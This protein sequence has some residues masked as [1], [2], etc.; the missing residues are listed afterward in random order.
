MTPQGRVCFDLTRTLGRTWGTLEGC[1]RNNASLPPV[2]RDA[3][4]GKSGAGRHVQGA[5]WKRLTG[6][7]KGAQ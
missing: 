6:S 7:R 1:R 2:T 3:M 5:R 4:R